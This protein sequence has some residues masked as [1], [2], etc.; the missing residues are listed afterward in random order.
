METLKP[1]E[2]SEYYINRVASGLSKYFWDNIFKEIFHILKNNK[3]INSK[4]D[5]I[6]AIKNGRIWYERGAFRTEGSFSNSVATTLENMGAKYRHKAYYIEISKIPFEYIQALDYVKTNNLLKGSA[7]S[8]FLKGYALSK[9]DLKPFIQSSVEYM[10]K[11]LELDIVKSA[12]D[13]KIPIIELGITKPDIKVPKAKT[14]PIEEYWAEYDKKADELRKAIKEADKKEKKNKKGNKPKDDGKG[15]NIP[16]TEDKDS[17]N[18][19]PPLDSNGNPPE[20]SGNKPPEESD[21]N[22]P[23]LGEDITPPEPEDK[24]SD[25]GTQE[26]DKSADDLRDELAD[27]NKDTYQ[28]APQLDIKIDDIELDA[29][30][31][32]IA[33]DYTY[34]MEFWVRKWEAKN[35]I[36]MRQDVLKMIE[37]GARVPRI[38]EYFEKRWKIAKDKALFLA[39]NESH[40]AASVI[41]ATE[42]Q[43]IGCP[44][45]KW[46]RSSSKEKRE[47][48]KLYYGQFFTWDDKPILDEKLGIRGYPR[49]I[50]NC[51][52]HMLIVPPTLDEVINNRTESKGVFKRIKN[53]FT[54]NSSWEYKRFDKRK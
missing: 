10:F 18:N 5:V 51:K 38:A 4:D 46:G 2:V 39:E 32:K 21:K 45:Y 33:E 54:R 30:S 48:H 43:M 7:I 12:Q 49:Q 15:G 27:L 44:G 16:P 29:K 52:C 22:Q 9:I 31:K 50:W 8:N 36:K 11:K 41:K 25:K 47:L 42:Y 13:K 53:C 17:G 19:P 34:N 26:E 23:P 20:D 6:N 3:V 35:I 40:L 14:K 24:G 28:N 1:V 37:E